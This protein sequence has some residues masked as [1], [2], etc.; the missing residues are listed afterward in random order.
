MGL[1]SEEAP[2]GLVMKH[3]ERIVLR[4]IEGEQESCVVM[5]RRHGCLLQASRG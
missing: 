3:E 5:L 1:S 4:G 2:H